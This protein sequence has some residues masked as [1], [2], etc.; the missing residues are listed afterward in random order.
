MSDPAQKRPLADFVVDGSDT[1]AMLDRFMEWVAQLGLELYPAQEEAVLEVMGDRHVILSTPTGSGKSLVATA[2]HFR[3]ICE[4]KRS[5]YTAPIK[6]L[7]SEKFFEM[8]EQLGAQHVGMLTGDASINRD[9]PVICCTAEILGNI[10]LREGRYARVDYAVLD[11]FHYYADRDRGAAWQ[12]PLLE[13]ADARFMLMSATLGDMSQI[14]K[15]LE[16]ST[17][18]E[19]VVV[20]SRERPV[21]LDFHYVDTSLHRTVRDLI[22]E[23]KAPVYVVNFT[24]RDA[25]EQ[26]QN[27]TSMNI[28]SKEEK[29]AISAAIGA[30]RF[31]TPYGKDIRRLTSHGIGLHHAGLLPKY[32]LLIERLAQQGLLKVISGT[33]TL[34]VG[35]NIPIRTVLFTKLYKFDGENTRVL[36]VRD[37]QQ[38]SGRAGRKGFDDRGSVVCQ[39]P[40]HVVDNK[41]L[42]EKEKQSGKKKKAPRKKPPRGFVHYDRNTFKKLIESDPEPLRSSFSV[43]HGMIAGL[44]ERTMIHGKRDGGYRRLISTLR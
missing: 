12:L 42:E 26:A 30:F 21:P 4:G 10:A 17:G 36:S 43:N 13:L 5:Y 23:K 6:A 27:L 8:C 9:A 15:R 37:F 1:D 40:E 14:A 24:Q 18:T 20:R 28:T 35:V 38:I 41:E 39:A 16:D 2:M 31:D 7:V 32:R 29:K 25:A 11:E 19:A 22:E 34:G 44:L 33:D 3:A